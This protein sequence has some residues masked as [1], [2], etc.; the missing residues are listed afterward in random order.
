VISDLQ[1][2]KPKMIVDT[3]FRDG[4]RVTPLN[5]ALRIV[6]WIFGGRRDVADLEPIYQFVGQHCTMTDEVKGALIYRCK[7]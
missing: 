4:T 6:W 1:A 3:T 7:Y 2:K 5:S